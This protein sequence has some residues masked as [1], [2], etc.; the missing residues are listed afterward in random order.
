[1]VDEAADG[2]GAADLLRQFQY[3][4]VLLDLMMPGID[5]FALLEKMAGGDI[6]SPPVVLVVTPPTAPRS[7]GS[8]RAAFTASCVSR[9]MPRRSRGWSSPAPRSR[10]AAPSERWP[11]PR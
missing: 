3:S 6:I 5:G 9:S 7:S 8:T 2:D 10:A 4:V 11:S 1:M